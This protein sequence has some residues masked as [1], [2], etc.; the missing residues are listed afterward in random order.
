ML[1]ICR[2]TKKS[3]RTRT[4]NFYAIFPKGGPVKFSLGPGPSTKSQMYVFSL[5]LITLP[6]Y[7]IGSE[8]NINTI[9]LWSSC[10]NC[11]RLGYNYIVTDHSKLSGIKPPLIK[12]IDSVDWEYGQG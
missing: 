8:N 5:L 10:L 6:C 9:L 12:L 7:L 3:K 4:L 11:T 1:N 2:G